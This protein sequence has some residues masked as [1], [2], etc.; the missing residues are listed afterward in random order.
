MKVNQEVEDRVR[1]FCEWYGEGSDGSNPTAAQWRALFEREPAR[2][3]TLVNLFKFREQADYGGN[4]PAEAGPDPISGYQAFERYASVSMPALAKA[5]GQ[6]LH[7][8][9]FEGMFCGTP[10]D[11]DLLVVADYPNLESLIHLYADADY[12]QAYSHRLAACA[13]QKVMVTSR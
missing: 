4:P 5:G 13:R 11:W 10:E 12:R 3:V 8:G 1:Q 6:F 2:S 7:A 9:P